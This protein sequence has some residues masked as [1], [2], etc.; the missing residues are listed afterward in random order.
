M[1]SEIYAEAGT[2]PKK[3]RT[4]GELLWRPGREPEIGPPATARPVLSTC[5]SETEIGGLLNAKASAEHA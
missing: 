2:A 4:R 3:Q 1:G 5:A